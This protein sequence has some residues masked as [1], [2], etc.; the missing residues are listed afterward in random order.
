MAVLGISPGT[1]SVGVAVITDGVL[2]KWQL[3]TFSE[4]WTQ[5]KLKRIITT[6]DVWIARNYIDEIAIKIPDELPL[7]K[8]YIKLVG[9]INILCEA[10]AIRPKYYTLSELKQAHSPKQTINKKQLIAFVLQ[11]FP[12]LQLSK[13]KKGHDK[14]FEAVGA[15]WT[16]TTYLPK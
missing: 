16:V 5:K 11:L 9:G 4:K 14:V 13:Q 2:V 7:S 15:A 8:A 3:H 10:R 1:R 12:D 6:L